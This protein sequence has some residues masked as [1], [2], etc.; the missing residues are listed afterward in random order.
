MFKTD[1]SDS[2]SI[3]ELPF[4]TVLGHSTPLPSAPKPPNAQEESSTTTYLHHRH[5]LLSSIPARSYPPMPPTPTRTPTSASF[6]QSIGTPKHESSFLNDPQVTWNT[7]DPWAESPDYLKTPKFLNFSTLLKSPA[8]L[9][10]TKRPFSGQDL[11]AQIASHVH[12]LSPN[13]DKNLPPVEPSRRLSSSPNPFSG[14]KRLSQ[15]VSEAE[16]TPLKTT[17][18][19]EATSSM[20]SASSMQTPPP[21]STSTTRR[22]AQKSQVAKL[23]KQSAASTRR[24][25]SPNLAQ[26]NNAVT[27]VSQIEASPGFPSLQFSPELFSFPP[28]TGPA[29]APILPQHKL[30]WDPDQSH[31]AMNIDFAAN[32]VFALGFGID[33]SLDPFTAS[34]EQATPSRL[35]TTAFQGLDGSHDD[36]AVFPVSAKVPSKKFANTR[37]T[38]S[39]VNPNM[40]FSSPGRSSELSHIPSS[41]AEMSA[42]LQPYAHQIQDAE[43][44]IE[45]LGPRKSKRRKGL[46]D[47]SPA[48]KAALETL[49][50]EADDRPA[51]RRSLTDSMLPSIDDLQVKA[52]LRVQQATGIQRRTSTSQQQRTRRLSPYKSNSQPRKS[53][54][55][56]LKIDPSGRAVTEAN[57]VK[58][59]NKP[60]L[61]S[62]MEVD[63]ATEDEESSTS[64][65]ENVA[66]SYRQSFGTV[67]QKSKR[68]KLTRFALDPKTHSQKSSYASTLASSS[69]VSGVRPTR[70]SRKQSSSRLPLRFDDPSLLPL[71][72]SDDRSSSTVVSDRLDGRPDHESD[73]TTV[74]SDDGKGDAQSELKKIR[75]HRDR[76]RP[77]QLGWPGTSANQGF[78]FFNQTSANPLQPFPYPNNSNPDDPFNISPTTITDPDLTPN[79][80]RDSHVNDCTRCVCRSTESDG[81][82]MILW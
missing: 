43:R 20:R 27:A 31:D 21:T 56:T 57:V 52:A 8:K 81:E 7:T 26:T 3:I 12:H 15:R 82:L 33:K 22:K 46:Q 72:L 38:T 47:D 23:A 44:E 76:S 50:D 66:T 42:T 24:M 62:Q 45:L 37:V 74:D 39:V 40:L 35:P 41:Q 55:L 65:E 34:Q 79:S 9:S 75:Q 80:A 53:S 14:T 73:E 17:L 36:L 67:R 48:V 10:G 32:D 6:A 29:T 59:E 54:R 51:V 77:R 25:S 1:L 58:K 64:S 30:F 5:R 4:T 70:G 60:F 28:S 63:S 2:S 71:P 68:G 13:P 49:R 61:K 78:E 19:E 16:L 69:T 11:E 18:D